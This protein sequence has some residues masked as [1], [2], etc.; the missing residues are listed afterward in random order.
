MVPEIVIDCPDCGVRVSTKAKDYVVS[1]DDFEDSGFFLVQCP[2]CKRPLFGRAERTMDDFNNW[3]W[4]IAERLWPNPR[5]T[6][7]GETVPD[8]AK[9]DIRD[10]HKCI[11]HGIYSAA[12]VLC[13]RA[14]ERVIRDKTGEKMIGRGLKGL[15]DKG[16]IDARLYD[17]A[18]V[19][20]QERNIGAHAVDEDISQDNAEDVLDFTVAIYDYVYTLHDK[21]QKFMMRK[22]A[23][24]EP[25]AA[26]N[27]GPAASVED[28]SA[29]GGPPLVS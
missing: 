11:T 23:K 1:G 16:V 27:G 10:A 28:S 3:H 8:L 7:L 19:L 17:W 26:P 15:R 25:S 13:G 2:S 9:K 14:L 18:E 6:E 5:R 12:A 20:R 24:T 21:Y 4:D 22:K 29:A